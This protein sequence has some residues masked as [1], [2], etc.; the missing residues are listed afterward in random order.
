MNENVVAVFKNRVPTMVKL[1][2]N[3]CFLK[4]MKRDRGQVIQNVI[5]NVVVLKMRLN[6]F[7]CVA[8]TTKRAR[9]FNELARRTKLRKQN[10]NFDV[11][12]L[13]RFHL[14]IP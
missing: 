11:G 13:T 12:S 8:N 2:P 4:V 9:R 3:N 1:A 6:G 7:R 5:E 14:Y 10:S